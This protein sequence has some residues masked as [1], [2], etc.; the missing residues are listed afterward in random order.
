MNTHYIRLVSLLMLLGACGSNAG[1][2]DVAQSDEAE[3]EVST[4]NQRLNVDS[5]QKLAEDKVLS[6]SW[7]TDGNIVDQDFLVTHFGACDVGYKRKGQPVVQYY[8]NGYCAFNGWVSTAESDCT[9]SLHMHT[10]GGFGGFMCYLNVNEEPL[11]LAR[12]CTRRC[13][14]LGVGGC[15]CDDLCSQYGD[16]CEDY[17]IACVP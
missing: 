3:R 4:N 11:Q 14:G 6:D 17:Q 15:Y 10:N 12:T 2:N 9:V 8:G 7:H 16:C 1:E 5:N 13:G